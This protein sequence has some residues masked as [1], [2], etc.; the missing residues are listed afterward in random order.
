[1]GQCFLESEEVFAWH[2]II[3]VY[4]EDGQVFVRI[5]PEMR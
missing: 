5:G 1:L 4:E 2:L 3:S